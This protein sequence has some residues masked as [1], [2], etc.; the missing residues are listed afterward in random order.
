MEL[1]PG[2]EPV[3]RRAG[4]DTHLV[5]ADTV[6]AVADMGL[7]M[8][9][10]AEDNPPGSGAAVAAAVAVAELAGSSESVSLFEPEHFLWVLIPAA[11]ELKN[12][13]PVAGTP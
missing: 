6:A 7:D 12:P 10:A 8:E 3:A 11:S 4:P 1:A 5:L 2:M 9:L 13:S